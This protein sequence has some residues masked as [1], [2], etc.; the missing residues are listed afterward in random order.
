MFSWSTAS[1]QWNNF[2]FWTN[3]V[4][5]SNGGHRHQMPVSTGWPH[6]FPSTGCGV[7]NNWSSGMSPNCTLS[8][9]FAAVLKLFITW[10]KYHN[11]LIILTWKIGSKKN[12][13]INKEGTNAKKW[14]PIPWRKRAVSLLLPISDAT[15]PIITHHGEENLWVDHT[16]K[17]R[18]K[19]SGLSWVPA[20]ACG[21]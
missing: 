8:G 5:N 11:T 14:R 10:F 16:P 18:D 2:K 3:P 1:S 13:R 7:S 9:R 20:V 17:A 12:Q 19:T 15:A 6:N 4:G 21:I